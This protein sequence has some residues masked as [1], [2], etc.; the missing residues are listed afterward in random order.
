MKAAKPP[1]WFKT[2]EYRIDI[3]NPA[4]T[5]EQ[6]ELFRECVVALDV[7]FF[8]NEVTM[9]MMQPAEPERDIVPLILS[10]LEA[11]MRSLRIVP[12][13]KDKE[14]PW[15]SIYDTGTLVDHKTLFDTA[16]TSD[17]S[18]WITL[19]F[20]KMRV[21]HGSEQTMMPKFPTR[22]SGDAPGP[23][24]LDSLRKPR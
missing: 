14:G 9:E 19:R 1:S 24:R 15:A 21:S 20:H 3:D 22:S 11:D 16:D 2:N 10:L 12:C 23:V 18:H 5:T 13:R 6:V 8:S 7:S 4:W 17:S